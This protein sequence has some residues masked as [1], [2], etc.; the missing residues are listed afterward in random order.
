MISWKHVKHFKP[1]EFSDPDVPDSG[2]LIDGTTLFIL[3]DLR[4][5]VGWPIITHW[6]VGGCN[7]IY[8][9]H[10]HSNNSYHL[11]KN[12]CKAVDF[13]FATNVPARIQ[14][15]KVLTSNFT[16]IG[17]Y[18]NIWKWNSRVLSVGFHVDTRPVEQ[19]QV[20]KRENGK[21]IYLIR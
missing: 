8:G 6:K 2:M 10:G 13:H 21:Y 18:Q 4:S 19:T 1:I 14:I 12:G 7:D 17:I 15:H 16:G 3:E 11:E 5:R 9:T 20:W